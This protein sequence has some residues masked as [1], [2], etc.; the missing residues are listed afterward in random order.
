MKT[1]VL[2]LV[3]LIFAMLAPTAHGENWEVLLWGGSY[4][5][6]DAPQDKKFNESNPGLGLRYYLGEKYGFEV[7]LEGDYIVRNSTGGSL[8]QAGIGAHYPFRITAD[9]SILVG[10]A[11]GVARYE[12]VWNNKTYVFPGGYPYVGVRYREF[13]FTVGYVPDIDQGNARAYQTFL[14]TLNYRF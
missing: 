14:T 3:T 12:N 11:V 13:T 10:G 4:H 9:I 8:V 1:I 5:L 7:Y 6:E 2:S